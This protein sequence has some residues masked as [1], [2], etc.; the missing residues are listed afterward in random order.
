MVHEG[1]EDIAGE[2]IA[3]TLGGEVK[4]AGGGIVV[5]RLDYIDRDIL[6]LRTTEDVFLYGWGTDELSYRAKDLEQIERWTERSVKWDALLKIHHAVR[7]KPKGKPTYRF[8]AQMDG[9]HGYRRVD[10]LKAMARGLSG[11]LPNSWKP[12]EE[13]ASVEIWLTIRGATAI[14]GMRLSDKT[15]R[16]RTYK[17]EHLP[18]SIRPTVAAAMVQLADLKPN[19]TVLDP[20]CGAGTL[21][22]EAHLAAK[23]K[24]SAEGMGWNMNFLGGDIDERHTRA[25]Q[26]NLRQ[27]KIEGVQTWDARELPL[28]DASVDRVISNPPFGKQLSTPEA[29]LPLYRETIREMDRVLRPGGKAVLIVMDMKALR[30]A[31]ERVGWK[32]QRHV[33]LRMLGQRAFIGVY[34]KPL[35]AL[36]PP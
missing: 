26:V 16:H 17:H 18:A 14:C 35:S 27:F 8:V 33:Q 24:K 6:N 20:M 2:E 12:A 28:E 15:M 4:R 25:A 32:E 36:A 5:F 11:K 34:R 1:L 30:S 19:Q 13:N 10:A 23:A 29:I 21:L 3:R 9:V 31:A 7:P 22:C